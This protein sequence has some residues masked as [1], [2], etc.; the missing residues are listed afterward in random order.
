M[1]KISTKY[2]ILVVD[3]MERIL[4]GLSLGLRA[5]GYEV[6]TA[7]SVSRGL[8]A[9][10]GHDIDIA[11]LDVRLKDESGLTLLEKIHADNPALPVIM[12][13]GYGTIDAAVQAIKKGAYNYLQKPVNMDELLIYLQKATHLI[14]LERENNQLRSQRPAQANRLIF[15]S[16]AMAELCRKAE[17]LA[18]T[19]IP[20]L[21]QGESGTGK[22][23][24]A[25]F[26]HKHS[27]RKDRPFV[28]INCASFSK[29]L[30]DDELFGHEKGAFTGAVSSFR[31]VF[32]QADNGTLLLDELGEMG[33]DT[34]AKIL[35]AIQNQEIQRLGSSKV[36][37]LNVRFLAATNQ[38][39]EEKVKEGTF[40]EDLYYRLNTAFVSV[41]PLRERKEDIEVLLHH[42]LD[43]F[44]KGDTQ[45]DEEAHRMLLCYDWPGNIRELKN[46][47]QYASAIAS[48][49]RI[50]I[51][52]L[53]KKIVDACVPEKKFK[54]KDLME[55]E[56]I[57]AT[58]KEC[59]YNKSHAASLLGLSRAT[60]YNKIRQ[61]GLQGDLHG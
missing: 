32:E 56:L 19:D 46:T 49:N 1:S 38:D 50:G 28:K 45:I 4:D 15:K 21:I 36:M 6:V 7:Q 11:L 26:I 34:Q 27:S 17:K 23:L 52:D 41:S 12:F 30:L 29:T 20:V 24:I 48:G 35:R 42:F 25:E 61:Y 18:V 43:M 44:K 2:T 10:F 40:R 13:T 58:L 47:L 16:E 8:Q 14:E 3:D 5:A 60:I 33:L 54:S 57:A 53:P 59:N 9:Y 22:E 39:L 31:G 55:K 37:Q 51:D